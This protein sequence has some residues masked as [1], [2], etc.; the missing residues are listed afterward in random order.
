MDLDSKDHSFAKFQTPSKVCDSTE[1]CQPSH[2]KTAISL[3]QPGD[4]LPRDVLIA[5]LFCVLSERGFLSETLVGLTEIVMN[6]G[7]S[8]QRRF[9]DSVASKFHLVIAHINNC[10]SPLIRLKTVHPSSGLS[11]GILIAKYGS[12]AYKIT[13]LHPAPSSAS[14]S[15]IFNVKSSVNDHDNSINYRDLSRFALRIADD[16]LYPILSL[17]W[18]DQGLYVRI[19]YILGLPENCHR[20]IRSYLRD[21][22][23]RRNFRQISRI[24]RRL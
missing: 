12:E 23:D 8:F 2:I 22:K 20:K 5:T 3:I 10:K 17:W 19:P 21:I 24:L 1:L 6:P 13:F 18:Q 9:C 11:I 16:L 4:Q 7:F 15:Y 14:V